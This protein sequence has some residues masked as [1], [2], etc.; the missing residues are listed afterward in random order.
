MRLVSPLRPSRLLM[1]LSLVLASAAVAQDRKPNVVFIMSDEL[2]YYELSCMGN[3]NIKTPRIDAMAAEGVRFTQAL[4]GSS[5]C[6][7]TRACLMTGKHSGHT[8][9]RSNGGGTPLRA[10]EETVASVL[11]SA[12]YATGG[13]GKW[14]CGG[15][16]STGVPEEHGFDTFLGYYDQVHAHSYYPAYI[17]RNSEEVALKG[18][19]GGASGETYS[20]YRIV[21]AA[22]Q[23][24]R[25]NKDKPFFCY[26]PVTP[27]HGMFNIPDEDPAWQMYKDRDWPESAR[28]YAAMV[29]MLD[30]QVGEILD[31]LRE[32][33]LEGNTMVVFCGDNGGNDYFRDKDHA[34]GFHG[35][36]V[37]PETGVAFRGHKGN[38]Y[39]GGLRIPMMVRWPGRIAPGRVSDRLWSFPDVLPTLAELAGV[40][41]PADVDGMSIV[42]ELLGVE[43]AGREQKDHPFL[44]WELGQQVAV[45]KGHWKAIRSK[46]NGAWELYDLSK[47]I[48]EATDVAAQ[49]ADLLAQM[50]A[51]AESAHTPVVSGTF[52][53]NADHQK[54]RDAKWGDA[55]RPAGAG[56]KVSKMP[57]KGL[58]ARKRV[59]LV[60]VSSESSSNGKLANKAFDGK[61]RSHWHT[62]WQG[63]A[64]RHPHDLVLDLGGP[65]DVTGLRYLARQDNGWNGAF[66]N[67]E[68]SVA[69]KPDG[70]TTVALKGTFKK[71]K[72]AQEATG[73]AVRGSYVRIRVLS[74]VSDGPWASAAEIGIVGKPVK[75]RR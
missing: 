51:M 60:S 72:A 16:G 67:W 56:R 46:R 45:R 49:H 10:G 38:L 73:E 43:A 71:E 11:K 65:C 31:L 18:N 33:K 21:D 42:P 28:R 55:R 37:N 40:Q 74:E 75:Q 39:E 64:D 5:L 70:F 30:R 17:V 58:I 35:P 50:Q 59:R 24:I 20:H 26:M 34:R 36:N 62:S 29:T 2:G 53:D 19:K 66:A 9:V 8:S 69:D 22:K 61:P 4:A 63:G 14:G 27:P 6:A 25:D 47:D 12:G 57:R 3:P 23:F 48:S 7:P 15:R 41:A 13:F 1:I 32:L 68:L 54:D 44:Y 52:A